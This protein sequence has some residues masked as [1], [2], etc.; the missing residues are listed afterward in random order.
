[1]RH[2]LSDNIYLIDG[3][4]VIYKASITDADPRACRVEIKEINRK[5]NPGR[6]KLHIA[7]APP[8]QSDRFEW[9]VEKAVE[10]GI[11]EITPIKCQRSERQEI[12]VER[13]EKIVIASMK[14]AI[15]AKKP[16]I[17]QIIPYTRFIK[18][19]QNS[20]PEKYIAY[21]GE[22]K[23]TLL[24]EAIIKGNDTI[25]LIGPEGDFTPDEIQLAI[26]SGFKPVS[27]GSTRLRTETAAIVSC[28]AYNLSNPGL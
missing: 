15:I 21:C 17:N 14:Q 9:F 8:K 24:H 11:D 10:I 6:C 25:I 2:T 28:V 3:S 5:N 12:K 13:F 20:N 22:S 19:V 16:V 7:I 4:G 27:L 23:K 26:T 1:M 18:T